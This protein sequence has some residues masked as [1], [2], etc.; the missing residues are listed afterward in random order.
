MCE[1]RDNDSETASSDG[2]ST[3]NHRTCKSEEPS[4]EPYQ[5][6]IDDMP[7]VIVKTESNI[8][9]DD[10]SA[11]NTTLD[12]TQDYPLDSIPSDWKTVNNGKQE[13]RNYLL[14]MMF[15]EVYES[16]DAHQIPHDQIFALVPGRL[17]LLSN[18][19]KYKVN[20]IIQNK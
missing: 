2:S 11:A 20:A 8:S 19:V 3:F 6:L 16:P 13:Y 7:Q 18:V 14:N 4:K 5:H 15:L 10:S 1:K 17:S 12:K 9:M